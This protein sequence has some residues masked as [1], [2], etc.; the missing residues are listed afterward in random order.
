MEEAMASTNKPAQNVKDAGLGSTRALTISGGVG[1]DDF[2]VKPTYSRQSRCHRSQAFLRGSAEF[3]PHSEQLW[4][5]DW[6]VVG[7]CPTEQR[8][9]L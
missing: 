3:Y 8:P 5:L 6:Q 1:G 7:H 9:N 2:N 4:L